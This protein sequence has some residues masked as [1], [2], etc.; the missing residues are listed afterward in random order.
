MD[1]RRATTTLQL[2]ICQMESVASADAIE[3]SIKESIAPMERA[4]FLNTEREPYL[5]L[6]HRGCGGYLPDCPI[7][8]YG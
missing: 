3:R 1:P 5:V 8:V 7:S 4:R 2:W 6:T